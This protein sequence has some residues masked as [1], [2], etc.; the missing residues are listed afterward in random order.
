VGIV[1]M[2]AAALG[3]LVSARYLLLALLLKDRVLGLLAAAGFV[4]FGTAA[5]VLYA[6]GIL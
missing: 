2:G 3:V 5:L 4:V 6:G 1:L